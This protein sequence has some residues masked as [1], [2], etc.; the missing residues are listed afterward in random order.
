MASFPNYNPQN[1]QEY[2]ED[3]FKNPVVADT[4]EPGST[5]KVIS[6]SAAIN[7]KEVKPSTKCD[8]CAGPIEIGGFSIRTWNNK[9]YP[10]TTMTE[11]LQH[12]DNTGM[13]FVSKKLGLNK[14]YKYIKD[15]GLDSPTGVDLQDEAQTSLRP[16]N[17]WKE[18]DLATASFGQGIAITG[19]QMV[20]AVSVIANGGNLV[21]PQIVSKISDGDKTIRIEPEIE[22]KNLISKETAEIVTEMMVNAV[23]NG[24]AKYFLP[25]GFK[26]AGKTGTAQIPIDGHYDPNKTIAS[27]VGFAPVDD[28]KFVMLVRFTEPTTSQFG[29]ETAAPTFFDIARDLFA[30]FG[31]Y[32]GR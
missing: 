15:F 5:F 6:M 19:I 4:Y 30:Y 23:E 3:S 32:P 17:D 21:K 2:S 13:V 26:V 16:K 25:K 27:F 7:E 22:K 12:S 20:R 1:W 8:I 24:E 9:Y 31:V 18:I 14:F 29:S 28:P 10:Q 11:T